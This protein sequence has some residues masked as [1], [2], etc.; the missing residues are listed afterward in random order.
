[1]SKK[2]NAVSKKHKVVSVQMWGEHDNIADI[3]AI[4]NAQNRKYWTDAAL[5]EAYENE[6]KEAYRM[7]KKQLKIALLEEV[8]DQTGK[9]FDPEAL[10]VVWARRFA[11]YKRADLIT[12]DLKRFEH[13]LNDKQ[14]LVQIIWAGKPY[15]MDGGAVDMFNHLVHFT[16]P[17]HNATVLTGYELRLSA[18]LKKGCDVWLNNPRIPQEASGTSGMTAAMNGAINFST[19]DGWILEFSK[20]GENSFVI[21]PV[22]LEL[23]E[24]QQDEMDLKNMMDILESEI[25]PTYYDRPNEWLR[26][27]WNGTRDV[28][29]QFAARRMA[30]D[31]YKK[32]YL[33]PG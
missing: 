19:D 11:G 23:S 2:A 4:T 7:R 30:D 9:V 5:E 13:V 1:M 21:P 16:R 25:I 12:R 33:S 15:P 17:Y 29:D 27:A 8:A 32:L 18:L 3:E 28:N 6:D 10:T 22:D 24:H 14:R 20:H 31:Y 26:I